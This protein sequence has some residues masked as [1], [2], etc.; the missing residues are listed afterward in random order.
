MGLLIIYGYLGPSTSHAKTFPGSYRA[1]LRCS[2]SCCYPH[3]RRVGKRAK[4]VCITTGHAGPSM[5]GKGPLQDKPA[6][7]LWPQPDPLFSMNMSEETRQ[8]KFWAERDDVGTVVLERS[9][10]GDCLQ[11]VHVSGLG[12]LEKLSS[13]VF[14]FSY[15]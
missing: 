6:L 10:S 2:G 1:C 15:R 12:W 5:S 4:L 8:Q 13:F 14:C 7:T 11:P 3:A 9:S